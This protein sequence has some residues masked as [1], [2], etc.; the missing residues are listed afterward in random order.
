MSS[1]KVNRYS[2]SEVSEEP[3]VALSSL[4]QNELD[5]ILLDDTITEI[6][7]QTGALDQRRWRITYHVFFWL[8]MLSNQREGRKSL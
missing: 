1:R 2:K 5:E 4:P 8:M 6:A 7:R 3:T